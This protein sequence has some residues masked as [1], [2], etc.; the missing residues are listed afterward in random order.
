M[1]S[2]GILRRVARVSSDVS[3]ER[4]NSIILVTGID[5][6][7]TMYFFPRS[8]LRLLVTA[9]V[10]SNSPIHDILMVGDDSS[11][12]TSVLITATLRNI[13]EDD[14]LHSHHRENLKSYIA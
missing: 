6:R 8:V 7:R 1:L 12:E 10:V 5:E 11:Y 13:P 9:N 14:I 2:S 3:G 4:I